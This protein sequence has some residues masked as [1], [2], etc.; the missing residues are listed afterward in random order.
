[1]ATEETRRLSTDTSV[2]S[3]APPGGCRFRVSVCLVG[4]LALRVLIVSSIN[5]WCE[6]PTQYYVSFTGARRKL[7]GVG[8]VGIKLCIR[9]NASSICSHT[10]A[11]K[12]N[13]RDTTVPMVAWLPLTGRML[14]ISMQSGPGRSW[15]NYRCMPFW[16]C[17]RCR[18]HLAPNVS[19]YAVVFFISGIYFKKGVSEQ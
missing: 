9:C 18:Q 3:T 1:M 7:R 16:M 4:Q 8:C 17:R 14:L 12:R 15:N 2:A 6:V 11:G 5:S 19:R 13:I 10:A